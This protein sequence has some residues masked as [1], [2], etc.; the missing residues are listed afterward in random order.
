MRLL[1]SI[2]PLSGPARDL[3]EALVVRRSLSVLAGVVR[4]YRSLAER[5][6]PEVRATVSVAAGLSAGEM[7]QVRTVLERA[8]G[9]RV[10][11]AM[12]T[13]RDLVGGML[14]QVGETI[15]DGTVK[16]AF[17]RLERQLVQAAGK[18]S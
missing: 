5:K 14:I 8:L 13:D 1:D 4:A 2:V 3:V 10:R 16:G 15:V 7:A 12:R 17:D 18:E 11:L 6:S 9:K